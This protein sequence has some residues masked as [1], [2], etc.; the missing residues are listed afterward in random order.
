MSVD[1]GIARPAASALLI[2][3]GRPGFSTVSPSSTRVDLAGTC[4]RDSNAEAARFPSGIRVPPGRAAAIRL[5]PA[6]A[7][8]MRLREAAADQVAIVGVAQAG[9]DDRTDEAG[10]QT[11]APSTTSQPHPPDPMRGR[12]AALTECRCG[13]PRDSATLNEQG[14][15]TSRSLRTDQRA[16][17]RPRTLRLPRDRRRRS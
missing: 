5:A 3:E 6:I 10:N 9:R 4:S 13:A 16:A 15:P 11:S 2:S 8:I 1:G 12:I 17:S 14:D 7:A